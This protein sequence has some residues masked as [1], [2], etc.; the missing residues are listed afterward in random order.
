MSRLLHLD[1]KQFQILGRA[2]L[3]AMAEH[4]E[5]HRER[6]ESA[7]AQDI[8]MLFKALSSAQLHRQM[9]PLARSAL[10]RAA[11]LAQDDGLRET[12]L[13]G[14]GSLCMGF[15]PLIRSPELTSRHRGHA[16]RVF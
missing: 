4:L 7:S 14:L 6:F 9:R 2:K 3:L 13:E 10:E 11:V 12:N 15:L 5:L 16:L 8:G 1:E